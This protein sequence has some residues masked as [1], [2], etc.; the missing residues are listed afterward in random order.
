MHQREGTPWVWIEGA[1]GFP[2]AYWV[3]NPVPEPKFG[4]NRLHW[5]VTLADAS[6]DNLVS[7][8]ATVIRVKDEEIGW[9]VKADPEGNEFCAF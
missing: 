1:G 6:V 7:L 2:Y 3:F 8:G 9:T 5:D 4:K